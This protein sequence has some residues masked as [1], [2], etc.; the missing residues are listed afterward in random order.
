MDSCCH[1]WSMFS[2]NTA[3]KAGDLQCNA[4]WVGQGPCEFQKASYNK[5][6]DL[7]S[8]PVLPTAMCMTPVT[9]Q[10]SESQTYQHVVCKGLG[11]AGHHQLLLE[12]RLHGLQQNK[13]GASW[14]EHV[15]QQHDVC[16]RTVR[17]TGGRGGVEHGPGGKDPIAGERGWTRTKAVI[18]VKA[19][20]KQG[21][22]R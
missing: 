6:A 17:C 21:G 4:S 13:L 20:W 5:P 19:G 16:L 2:N 14:S 18:S 7:E 11:V 3:L 9:L 1:H 8:I 12:A 22:A 15:A 10:V